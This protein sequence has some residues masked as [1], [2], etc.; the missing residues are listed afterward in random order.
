MS[1][2]TD[3]D[4]EFLGQWENITQEEFWAAVREAGGLGELNVFSTLTDPD[5]TYGQR[6][7]YTA[8]G[9]SGSPAPLL[10]ICDY[11]DDS[12]KVAQRLCRRFVVR[13][14]VR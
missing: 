10:D 6:Q 2:W 5:G 4:G 12:G 3:E 14:V 8:W 11:L 1:A 7:I 9:R 13:E